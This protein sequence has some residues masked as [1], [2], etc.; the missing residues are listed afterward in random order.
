MSYD[1]STL[2]EEQR[3]PVFDTEGAVLVTA[4]AGSGKTRLLTHRIAYL[5]EEKGVKP[6]NILAITFTNKAANEIKER[7]GK[8]LG[9][10]MSLLWGYTFHGVCNQ[11]LR[12]SI[13]HLDGYTSSYSIYSEEEKAKCIKRVAKSLDIKDLKIKEAINYI[14][15]KKMRYISPSECKNDAGYLDGEIVKIYELYEQELKKCNALDF[16]DLLNKTYYLLKNNAEVREYYQDKFHYIH[17]DEFQDTNKVQYDIVRIL[18]AKHGNVFAVGDEDQSIYGWRGANF[19]NITDFVRDYPSCRVYKLEQNYRSSEKILNIANKIIEKNKTR[20]DKKLWTLRSGGED[21]RCYKARTESEEADFVFRTIASLAQTGRYHFSD[22]SILV[23][24]NSLSR[25]FEERFMQHGVPYKMFGGFKFYDRKEVKDLLAYLKII[26]NHKDNEAIIRVIN[27]PKRGIGEG[28][29]AQLNN[30]ASFTGKSLY[31]VIFDLESNEDLPNGLIK[32]VLPFTNVL[33]CMDNAYKTTGSIGEL[34][35]YIIKLIGLKECYAEDTEENES[36]KRN[37]RE[38]VGAIEQFEE[39]NSGI[40]LEEYVQQISL[41]SDLDEMDGS[42]TVTIA[43]IH[44]AKGLE[45][46]VVFVVGLEEGIFPDARRM[47]N[48]AE[49]EEERRLMYVAVTRAKER[50]YLTFAAHRFRYGEGDDTI[51]SRFLAEG[52]F[53]TKQ[54]STPRESAYANYSGR[55]D[56]YRGERAYAS[57]GREYNREEVPVYSAPAPTRSTAPTP[58]QKNPK[59]YAVGTRVRHNKFGD[60]VVVSI[61]EKKDVL[62]EIQFDIAGRKMLMLDYAPLEIIK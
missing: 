15:D 32:K 43:T 51:P 26:A 62:I 34:T 1:L 10:D 17:V 19:A 59:D 9:E 49:M 40:T 5:I 3:K 50:L 21:V 48:Y 55:Y 41:Y 27:F 28:S 8:M 44:S 57:Y 35:R 56:S 54:Q 61:E 12:K 39:L 18:G 37:I 45:F 47:E 42:D 4:G 38:L 30:Y 23:R 14:S 36:R 52:G 22:F 29:V 25:S 13:K 7:L 58:T 24:V 11:I 53:Q 60:G 2:N 16:D 46:K 20:F 31:D 33:K 6:Y